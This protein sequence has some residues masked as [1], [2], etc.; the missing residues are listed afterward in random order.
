MQMDQRKRA[1]TIIAV[2]N[3]GTKE[4]NEPLHSPPH[5]VPSAP[6]SYLPS[7]AFPLP[8]QPQIA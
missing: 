7:D 6:P 1:V 2:R 3:V 5:N 4:R 8:R